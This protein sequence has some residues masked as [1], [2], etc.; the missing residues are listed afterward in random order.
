[1]VIHFCEHYFRY[2]KTQKKDDVD[3]KQKKDDSDKKPMPKKIAEKIIKKDEIEEQDDILAAIKK[4]KDSLTGYTLKNKEIAFLRNLFMEKPLLSNDI[5][6]PK[7]ILKKEY[8][9]NIIKSN[10]VDATY[11]IKECPKPPMMVKFYADPTHGNSTECDKNNTN[12]NNYTNPRSEVVNLIPVDKNPYDPKDPNKKD[13]KKE[14]DKDKEKTFKMPIDDNTLYLD[15]GDF[16]R[17]MKA[18]LIL[19]YKN[20]ERKII[21]PRSIPLAVVIPPK[22]KIIPIPVTP[23]IPE[24]IKSDEDELI[25]PIQDRN[26]GVIKK[27]DE[28]AIQKI[29]NDNKIPR[30]DKTQTNKFIPLIPK[31]DYVGYPKYNNFTIIKDKR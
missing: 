24:E 19:A 9:M 22:K 13:E 30:P 17:N 16:Y 5:L 23:K 2:L 25:I 1:M 29:V 3:K 28:T 20:R 18:D 27:D 15:D 21:V 8:S 10:K 14:D 26:P 6:S 11:L 4:I 12:K 31:P 7:C